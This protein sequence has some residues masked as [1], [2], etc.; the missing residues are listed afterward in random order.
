MHTLVHAHHKHH[1]D[2]G[3]TIGDAVGSHGEVAA[4]AHELVVYEDD[5]H[6]G[7]YIHEEWRYAD[8]KD[9]FYEFLL[10]SVD[11]MLE[12]EQLILVAEELELPAECHQLGEDGGD[13]GSSYAPSETED[14]ESVEDDVHDDREDGGEH[15]LPW[16]ARR[17][18]QGV[19]AKVHVAH[20]VA[21][22]DNHHVFMSVGEGGFAGSE[23][24]KDRVEQ[25]Q[26]DD[27][28][29]DTDDKIQCECVTQNVLCGLVVLLS[30]LHADGSGSA[31]AHTGT[32]G[33]GEVHEGE[34]DGETRDSQGTHA[35]TDEH[36]I[37]DVV[38]RGCGHRYHGRQG[39]LYEQLAHWFGA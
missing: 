1:E 8:G 25:Q 38:E 27:A 31:H 26:A 29:A 34:G 20:H 22:Q 19:H 37:H 13:G 9:L 14:E 30:Q 3:D 33:S 5:H 15:R 4:E 2:H 7:A 17:S 39:I 24:T 28:E 36:T 21:Q 6:A 32:E 18:Q 12:M 11:A 10:Q 16:F 35:L 23:E